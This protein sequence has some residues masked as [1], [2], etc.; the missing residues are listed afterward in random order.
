MYP[1]TPLEPLAWAPPEG[2]F[3]PVAAN[4]ELTCEIILLVNV[5]SSCCFVIFFNS[6]SAACAVCFIW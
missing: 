3:R 1:A 5:C 4:S 6:D 2:P